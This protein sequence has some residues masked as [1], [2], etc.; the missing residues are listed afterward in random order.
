M[1]KIINQI[2]N[3]LVGILN[4]HQIESVEKI[5][6]KYLKDNTDEQDQCKNVDL[7]ENGIPR[8]LFFQSMIKLFIVKDYKYKEDIYGTN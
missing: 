1:N 8:Y 2:K 5:L 3:D 4:K 6:N 7:L